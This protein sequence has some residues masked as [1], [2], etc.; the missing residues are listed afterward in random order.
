MI[1]PALVRGM[2]KLALG[3]KCLE[4]DGMT[5]KKMR[6]MAAMVRRPSG[7]VEVIRFNT[8]WSEEEAKVTLDRV[9]SSHGWTLMRVGPVPVTQEQIELERAD[10]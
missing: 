6:R 9:L 8:A 3:K 5:E 7:G 4:E 1:Q 2:I 10:A